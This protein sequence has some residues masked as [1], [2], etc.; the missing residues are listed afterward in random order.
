MRAARAREAIFSKESGS[1]DRERDALGVGDLRYDGNGLVP[2]V[3]QQCDTGEVL[4]V[5]YMNA[6]ALRRTIETGRTWF[7]SRSRQQYWMK[8]ESSG[9]VQ[10]VVEVRYDCDADCLLVLV[11]QKG[12][13]ACHTGERTC[14]YR[15]LFP[16]PGRPAP[17]V[18]LEESE[19]S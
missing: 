11:D 9:H 3:V 15:T 1:M 10:D 16:E 19:F 17:V 5:A 18:N 14:F 6:D 12:A 7:W 8:G 2:A 4:M 13:G